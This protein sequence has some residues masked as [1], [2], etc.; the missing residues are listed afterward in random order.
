MLIVTD[1][2]NN[3]LINISYLSH[4]HSQLTEQYARKI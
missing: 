3:P 4:T 2:L 1:F